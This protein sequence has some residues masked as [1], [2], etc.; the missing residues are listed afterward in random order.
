[1]LCGLA[2]G[3]KTPVD[4][5]SIAGVQDYLSPTSDQILLHGKTTL[6]LLLDYCDQGSH[7]VSQS[8]YE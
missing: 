2:Q 6:L 1:M 5:F 4:M 7:G 3:L 8:L